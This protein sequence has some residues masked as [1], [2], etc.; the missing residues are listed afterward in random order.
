MSPGRVPN[1]PLLGLGNVEMAATAATASR[2]RTLHNVRA[3]FD[4]AH[5]DAGERPVL[6]RMFW[7]QSAVAIL[8]ALAVRLGFLML[9][10]GMMDADEAVLGVQAE[11]I[12]QG[13]RPIYFYGQA[14]MGSW[15]AYLLAPLVALF[16]PSAW[17]IHVVTLGESLLLIPLTGALALKLYGRR[18]LL[19]ALI[20]TA[21]LPLFDTTVA[22]RMLGGYVETLALG[23]ALMLL[24][25][26]IVERWDQGR[27]TTVLWIIVGFLTGLALWIDLLI[28]YYVI[29]CA[30]WLTP[31]ALARLLRKR[32]GDQPLLSWRTAISSC[33]AS[34][35][36]ACVGSAPAL[37]FAFTQNFANVTQFLGAGGKA[38]PDVLRPSVLKYYIV[39]AVPIVLGIRFRWPL[40]VP[41]AIVALIGV[42]AGIV[43]LCALMYTL[44]RVL[45]PSTALD[46]MR[47]PWRRALARFAASPRQRWNDAF[48]LLLGVIITLMFWR[49]SATN[50]PVSTYVYP[51]RYVVP[52]ITTLVLLLARLLGDL[53]TWLSRSEAQR[54]EGVFLRPL[55]GA[56]ARTLGT[57]LLLITLV[58]YVA[59]YALTDAP[60][61]MQSPFAPGDTFPVENHELLD[62]LEAQHIHDVWVNHW[63]GDVIMYLSN[64]RV[65]CGDYVG[66]VVMHSQERFPDVLDAI[67]VSDRPSF[68]VHIRPTQTTTAADLALENLHIAY[69]S[70]RFGN[71]E[72]ITPLT[73]TVQPQEILPALID[74]NGLG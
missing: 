67:S 5:P 31:L 17:A 10:R 66:V 33:L 13:A 6:T 7:I 74:G 9:S 63:V 25:T 59:P 50:A 51:E 54:A 3:A 23:T 73:R 19:P 71:L 36:A 14:Y 37:Y 11:R 58:V 55:N 70:A 57:L 61:A 48:P 49:S 29:A 56:T 68:I 42:V 46:S 34:L 35:A 32:T 20:L 43:A 52:L 12:L 27:S 4:T 28:A 44:A 60:T 15:D 40:H 47:S 39:K 2:R 72:V 38:L 21:L 30:L 8:V 69:R 41:S 24:V 1:N 26:L 18:A 65:L 22:L 64:Q 62:Y 45:A 53:G 16:G